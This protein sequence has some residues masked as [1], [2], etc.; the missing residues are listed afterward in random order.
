MQWVVL[1]IHN[2]C[3]QHS[4]VFLFNVIFFLHSRLI[5]VAHTHSWLATAAVAFCTEWSIPGYP[6]A[7]YA[8]KC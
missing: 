2:V 5:R 8:L 1:F 6:T 4:R 3:S 7:M